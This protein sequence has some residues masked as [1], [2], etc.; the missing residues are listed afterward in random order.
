[1]TDLAKT[2]AASLARK[3]IR[4][5]DRRVRVHYGSFTLA[6][7]DE[8]LV[9]HEHGRVPVVFIPRR[10]LPVEFLHD[11][12]HVGTPQ[13]G[14]P[15]RYWNFSVGGQTAENGIWSFERPQGELAQLAGYVA[16]DAAQVLFEIDAGDDEVAAGSAQDI[17]D[18][19]RRANFLHE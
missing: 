18:V 2:F 19:A 7:T 8:A 10:H 5:I 13:G 1:M 12:G 9:F 16:F 6:D 11:D 15:A 14:R 3:S 17:A 4:P